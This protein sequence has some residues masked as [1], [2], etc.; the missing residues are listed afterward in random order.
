MTR[1]T[2]FI[3]LITVFLT[4]LSSTKTEAG[5]ELLRRDYLEAPLNFET[6]T[7]FQEVR[8]TKESVI[9]FETDYTEDDS[10]EIGTEKT[11]EEGG[12][13]KN[14]RV[15]R[16]TYWQGK[17]YYRVLDS[18][19][20]I[21]PKKR[22]VSRGTKI[23]YRELS[24]PD[25]GKLRYWRKTKVWATSYDGNCKGCLGRTYSGTPVVVGT[26]AVDPKVIV[27][28]SHFYVPGYGLCS[29]LDIGGAIKG[30]KIDLGFPDISQGWWSAR[31][32]DI[33][34]VDGE[35]KK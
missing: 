29:A 17:E 4:I 3:I 28:G 16:V 25:Q 2:G 12:A 22:K 31:F 27:L 15:F 13:G 35:P 34:L 30:D 23:I 26:C 5:E 11:L 1:F 19:K 20:I 10:A 8:E 14:L 24:T 32:V 9:P 6:K 21:K 18:E 7:N 33:Y